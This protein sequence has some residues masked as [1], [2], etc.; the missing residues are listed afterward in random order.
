MDELDPPGR[1]GRALPHVADPGALVGSDERLFA[2]P[3]E[4]PRVHRDARAGSGPARVLSAAA[5]GAA[6]GVRKGCVDALRQP[7]L[8]SREGP[9]GW[10]SLHLSGPGAGAAGRGPLVA[11]TEG[12]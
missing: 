1:P 12:Q 4:E 11:R 6:C 9:G 5:L 8:P 3:G 2:E 10:I 7:A